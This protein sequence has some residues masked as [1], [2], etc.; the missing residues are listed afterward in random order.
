MTHAQNT[1][2]WLKRLSDLDIVRQHLAPDSPEL[3]G[4][5]SELAAMRERLPTAI[6]KHY[7]ERRSGG[8]PAIVPVSSGIC[9]ECHLSL[10][11]KQLTELRRPGGGLHVCNHCGVFIFLDKE[12]PGGK[13]RSDSTSA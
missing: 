8:K 2:V 7:D 1:L 13:K 3:P 9:G 6:L 4:L 11:N 10:P 5:V 12:K